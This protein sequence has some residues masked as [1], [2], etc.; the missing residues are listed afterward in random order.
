MAG[1][2]GVYEWLM[3]SVEVAASVDVA[4]GVVGFV[5]AVVVA[6]WRELRPYFL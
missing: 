3:E 2:V 1:A 4:A 5:A 6:S